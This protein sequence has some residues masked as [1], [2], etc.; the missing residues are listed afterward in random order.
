MD[1]ALPPADPTSPPSDLRGQR[2]LDAALLVLAPLVRWL[3]RNGVNYGALA[4]GLKQVFLDQGRQELQLRGS[5]VTDSALSVLSGVHRKDVR[6]LGTLPLVQ[7]P[8][9]PSPASMVFTRW[10]TDARLRETGPDGQEQPRQV[11]QRQGEWPS[12]ESLA[13]EVSSDVH[14]RTLLD[15]LL[16]LGL[17]ELQGEEV[18]LRRERFVPDAAELEAAQTLAVN[19]ADHLRAAVHNL[20]ADAGMKLLEQSVYASGLSA[21]SAG[22]LGELARDLWSGAFNAMVSEATTR[23][24]D[25]EARRGR[26]EDLGEPVRMRFGAY[27]YR[28]QE[29]EEPATAER[30]AAVQANRGAGD[31]A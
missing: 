10:V 11:L 30:A 5:K 14:P 16:R 8:L 31:A 2:S 18:R 19:V 22:E 25:D 21:A 17:V 15:E 26:G 1:P 12:F 24:Q 28:E 6:A 23:W 20:G 9:Q 27:F 3:L 29:P 4:Q 7:V 13:R